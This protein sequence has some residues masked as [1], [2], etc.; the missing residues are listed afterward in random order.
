[1]NPWEEFLR[2]ARSFREVQ[3][4]KGVVK[5]SR[6][7]IGFLIEG[8]KTNAKVRALYDPLNRQE[9]KEYCAERGA[10]WRYLNGCHIRIR[11][12]DVPEGVPEEFWPMDEGYSVD[13]SL[14]FEIPDGYI[15]SKRGVGFTPEHNAILE[16]TGNDWTQLR[17][18]AYRKGLFRGVMNRRIP[19]INGTSNQRHPTVFH[20]LYSG[21]SFFDWIAEYLPKLQAYEQYISKRNKEP[22][23]L[24]KADPPNWMVES[25]QLATKGRPNIVE[26]DADLM[27][28]ETLILSTQNHHS[29]NN[30]FNPYCRKKYSWLG[31]AMIDDIDP[32]KEPDKIYI[33]RQDADRRR[34]KN[35]DELSS[36]LEKRGFEV[37]T[38]SDKPFRDQVK[39][40]SG[41]ETILGLH[42]AGL[43]HMLWATNPTIIEII[44]ETYLWPTFFC[45]SQIMGFQYDAILAR[46][47]RENGRPRD[48]D[49]VVDIEK[50]LTVIDKHH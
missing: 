2:Q 3:R 36:E 30:N 39:L 27:P 13:P 1:M 38:L 24:I 31:E 44:P 41:A 35:H 34:V 23:I 18:A 43:V 6:K 37:V 7:T 26:M 45:L 12:E 48:H 15:A 14:V 28:S 22:S 10:V 33:S 47:Y 21:T 50:L 42:G 19:I 29:V 32:S 20:L 16:S 11:R 49:V 8:D 40:V 5:A 25:L 9:L 17:L 4:D 46:T